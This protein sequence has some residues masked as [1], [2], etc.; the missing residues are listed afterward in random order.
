MVIGFINEMNTCLY[1]SIGD[2]V[3]E[4]Q[5]AQLFYMERKSMS[6]TNNNNN[7]NKIKKIKKKLNGC[8]P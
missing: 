7:N 2:A 3:S 6:N 4:L 8:C 1:I 5:K